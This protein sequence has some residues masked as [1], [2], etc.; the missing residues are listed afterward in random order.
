VR[1][2]QSHFYQLTESRSLVSFH[3]SS[4]FIVTRAIFSLGGGGGRHSGG[5]G[6]GYLDIG[7][8]WMQS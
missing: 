6:G 2:E 4:T 3:I 1:Q 5:G 8:L 7:L